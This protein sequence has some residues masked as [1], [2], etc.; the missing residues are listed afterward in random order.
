MSLDASNSDLV[1]LGNIRAPFIKTF[2]TY[3]R[4]ERLY[5]YIYWLKHRCDPEFNVL[6]SW[7]KK[8]VD[9][10]IKL[11]QKIRDTCFTD[12]DISDFLS[13]LFV[14][15]FGLSWDEVLA[16]GTRP[17]LA[18]GGMPVWNQ[19]VNC[20]LPQYFGLCRIHQ[21]VD[22]APNEQG[23]NLGYSYRSSQTPEYLDAYLYRHPGVQQ[24]QDQSEGSFEAEFLSSWDAILTRL[25]QTDCELCPNPDFGQL[26]LPINNI[27]APLKLRSVK[28]SHTTSSK[29]K[30]WGVLSLCIMGGHFAKFRYTTTVD[31]CQTNNGK[32]A[33][34]EA[35]TQIAT[36]IACYR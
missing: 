17:E 21:L 15:R 19:S 10:E 32:M 22:H 16:L 29:E 9:A 11:W 13:S 18:A 25:G 30:M 3:W 6:G 12:E 33:F 20:L 2:D 1:T 31:Y 7:T 14:D 36:F 5:R 23:R 4:R 35:F 27:E 26:T 24:V 28:F 34:H 8:D